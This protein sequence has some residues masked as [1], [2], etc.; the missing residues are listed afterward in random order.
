MTR[1]ELNRA[2]TT[3]QHGGF[4]VE[5][6]RA[7]RRRHSVEA[8]RAAHARIADGTP[9]SDRVLAVAIDHDVSLFEAADII[10]RS[11]TIIGSDATVAAT[12]A[13]G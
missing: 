5:P 3:I 9:A 10:R 12:I 2:M 8:L 4:D 11:P 6:R 7:E 1:D 13:N